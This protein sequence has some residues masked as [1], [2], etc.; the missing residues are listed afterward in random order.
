VAQVEIT[1]EHEQRGH[2]RFD[3]QV[4][5]DAGILRQHLVTLAWADYNLWSKDGS[6]EPSQVVE[7]AVGFLLLRC[8]ANQLPIKFDC[9]LARRRFAE[10]DQVIPALIR[11]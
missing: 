11:R 6:D 3:L 5:D 1:S 9:S 10:A 4:L 8:P 2:W 7:A